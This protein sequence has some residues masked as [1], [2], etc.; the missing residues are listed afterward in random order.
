M[1]RDPNPDLK[2]DFS[3]LEKCLAAM[4]KQHMEE[5]KMLQSDFNLQLLHAQSKVDKLK[6]LVFLLVL[7]VLY[8]Q[9]KTQVF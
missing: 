9:L 2:E 6:P 7:F 3:K 4:E 5:L 8:N 1:P